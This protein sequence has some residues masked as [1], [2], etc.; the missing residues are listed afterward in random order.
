MSDDFFMNFECPQ[1]GS[2]NAYHDIIDETGSYFVCPDC[3]YEWGD[4][5]LKNPDENSKDF[6]D[7]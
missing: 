5:N 4:E 1:C 2:E 7:F 6:Y 3:G